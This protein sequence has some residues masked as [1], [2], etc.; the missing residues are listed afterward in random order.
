MPTRLLRDGILESEAV[1]S[2]PWAAEVL[3]RRLMSVADDY[4]RFSASP[5]LIRANCYPLQIDKVSDSDV[6]KWLAQVAEAGLVRVYP[7]EDGKRYLEIVKF[8]Q[9]VRSKSKH[10]APPDGPCENLQ[11]VASNCEQA[12]AN[13]HLDV[14]E[15]EGGDVSNL[16]SQVPARLPT[17]GPQLV[18][19]E[20]K[21]KGPPDCPHVAILALW[22]EVLP[23]LPQHNADMWRGTRADHLRARWR[24]TA[25]SKGWQTEAEGLA[26]LRKLFGYVG[27]SAFLTGRAKPRGDARPFVIELEWLVNPTNWAKVHEGKY[28]AE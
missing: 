17:T 13:A 10:P 6:G 18:A 15:G 20:S 8:G 27:Q 2:L 14:F 26:Y 28:H 21:P 23:A 12:T 4:G 3:Y 5:K 24:E 19:V 16:L 11:T 7:A 1:C 25:V 22:A 9:Q